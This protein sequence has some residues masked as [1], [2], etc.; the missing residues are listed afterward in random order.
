MASFGIGEGDERRQAA[1]QMRLAAELFERGSIR[2]AAA[3]AKEAADLIRSALR[4][5]PGDAKELDAIV[6][7]F[8]RIARDAC[9]IL[10][11]SGDL[12]D[13]AEARRIL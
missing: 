12:S 3:P 1:E 10:L 6:G 2:D 9:Q 5:T 4:K 7:E 8:G 11:R 13:A